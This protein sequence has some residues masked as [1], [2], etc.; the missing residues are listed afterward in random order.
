MSEEPNPDTADKPF[1]RRNSSGEAVIFDTSN[2]RLTLKSMEDL[3]GLGV[4]ASMVELNILTV[5]QSFS[6]NDSY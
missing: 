3:Q 4:M 1:T 6:R 5:S 2:D